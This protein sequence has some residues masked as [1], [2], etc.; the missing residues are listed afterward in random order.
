MS[1]GIKFHDGLLL[2]R[3]TLANGVDLHLD[4]GP[5]VLGIAKEMVI[6]MQ[7][8]HGGT[9]PWIRIIWD[10]AGYPDEYINMATVQKVTPK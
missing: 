6:T 8:S 9:A 5:V 4:E 3:V 1:K 2:E 7:P 10:E